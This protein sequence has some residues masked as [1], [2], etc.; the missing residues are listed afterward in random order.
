MDPIA[1]LALT[2]RIESVWAGDQRWSRI[3]T[4]QWAEALQAID[5]GVAGT[6]F[7][8]LRASSPKCPSIADFLS[9]CRHLDT[10]DRSTREPDCDHCGNTG[11]EPMPD[12]DIDGHPYSQVGPCRCRRGRAA[13]VTAE[14]IA[15]VNGY[16]PR[17][18]A[19]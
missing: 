2:N 8:R 17:E 19:A 10:N 3:R 9:A 1:A 7:A 14:T 4:D 6:A 15:R 16:P 12:I 13:R 18:S 11:W 5:E